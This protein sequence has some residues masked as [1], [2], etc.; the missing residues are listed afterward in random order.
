MTSSLTIPRRFCGPASS[1]NGGWTAGALA[2]HLGDTTDTAV[3]V[4]LRTPP[5][6]DTPLPV[7]V[8][9]DS[10]SATHGETLVAVAKPAD[11]DPVPVQSV[12]AEAARAAEATYVGLTA[13][14]FPTCFACGT[15]RDP[16]D[17]LRIFPGRVDDD[18]DGRVRVAATWTPDA[19]VGESVGAG[20]D[21]AG[22]PVAWAALDC[23]G[24][25][26]GD[27]TDRLMV[28][29]TMTARVSTR[30]RIGEEHVLV[31]GARGTDGRRTFS[32]STLYDS[33]GRVVGSAEHIWFAVD[34]KDFA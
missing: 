23:I 29:G 8:D 9:D 4:V 10:A 25:W 24:G 22:L 13:H 16:G 11:H 15:G 7:V 30:P 28:L 31:G 5:P 33:Q 1:G 17:G 21:R 6:L 34:P 14:P 20:D 27:L 18:S 32:A 26:A 12:G 2:A 3:R 19:S